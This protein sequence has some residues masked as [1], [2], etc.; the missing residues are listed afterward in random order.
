MKKL[1]TFSIGIVISLSLF[2]QEPPEASTADHKALA[3]FEQSNEMMYRKMFPEAIKVLEQAIQRDPNFT[4]AYNRIG[5]CYIYMHEDGKAKKYFEKVIELN[6]SSTTYAEVYFHL[7]EIYMKDMEYA[8][9]KK[10]FEGFLEFQPR[11][12]MMRKVKKQIANCDFAVEAMKHPVDFKPFQMVAPVNVFTNQYFPTVT[13]DKS[14]LIY[15][16]RQ[17]MDENLFET[18]LVNNVWTEPT[19]LSANINTNDNEGT[20]SISADGKVIVFTAC[21]R[22]SDGLGSC[23]LYISYKKDNEWTKPENMGPTINSAAWES[24]PSLTADGKTIY[25][26]SGRKGSKGGYDVWTS[27]QNENGQWKNPENL[28]DKINTLGAEVSPFID[29]SGNVLYYSSEGKVGMG[30]L[31]LFYT[32]KNDTGWT[33]PQ[34]LGY[35]INTIDDEAGLFITSDQTKAYFSK[36][37]TDDYG[38]T[39]DYLYEFAFPE[40]LKNQ[41][42][43]KYAKGIVY[44][45]ATKQKIEGHIEIFDLKNNKKIYSSNSDAK[46]GEYMLVLT[47]GSEYALYAN[48]QGYLFK[49]MFFDFKNPESFKPTTLDIYL[50]PIKSGAF[51]TLANIFY[52]TGKF[53]LEDKSKTELAKL[54][55]FLKANPSLKVEISGHTDDVGKDLDNNTLSNN[56]AKSVYDFL[57]AAGIP[58][59]NLKYKGYGKVKPLVPNTSETNRAKN[60][61]IEFRIL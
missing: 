12:D 59:V 38:K 54:V 9:A 55:E 41:F 31:D 40:S 11:A 44:D 57:V 50:E 4:E 14:T 1:F 23:D 56:R 60:R 39:K 16:V 21:N 13:A 61:R 35:P 36:D 52:A 19:P 43:S 24:Q 6:P 47:Q 7:G 28:G 49:S 48:K 18:K 51:I 10:F 3:L 27:S 15:T 25:F 29:P 17:G 33:I 46:T 22:K 34:N 5:A 53:T 26:A 8:E 32:I 2:A 37:I 20:A 30:G 45:A 58:A 42:I